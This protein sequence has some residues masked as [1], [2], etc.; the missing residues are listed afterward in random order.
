MHK[1]VIGLV[2]APGSGK[3]F[4]ADALAQLGCAVIDADAIAKAQLDEPAVREQLVAW[5]GEGMLT[6]EGRVDRE[7]VG[8]IVFGDRAELEKLEGLVHPRVAAERDK[9]REQYHA[10]PGVVAIVE[11]VPLLMEK[12]LDARCD[13]VVFIDAPPAVRLARLAEARGW[14]AEQVEAREKNQWP[15]DIKRER[16]DD[17]IDNSGGQAEVLDRVRRLLSRLIP[18]E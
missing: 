1:P 12:G 8:R 10:D 11:D 14:S 18:Q 17:V 4:V 7:A 6:P 3:S 5:W 13:R 2:G 15:L 9:L 16:A